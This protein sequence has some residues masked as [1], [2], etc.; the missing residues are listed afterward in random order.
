MAENE[1]REQ[2]DIGQDEAWAVNLKLVV[3]EEVKE[4]VGLNKKSDDFDAVLKNI[5]AQALQNAVTLQNLVNGNV[6]AQ[7]NLVNQTIAD[8][9]IKS[10]PPDEDGK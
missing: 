1:R 4:L 3:A 5:T 9:A 8:V 2:Q 7:C 10:T 6:A